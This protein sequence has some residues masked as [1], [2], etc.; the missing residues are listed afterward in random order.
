MKLKLALLCSLVCVNAH[1]Y[2]ISFGTGE[3]ED[4]NI[5]RALAVNDAL[6]QY[7]SKEFD[8]KKQQICSERNADGLDCSFKKQIDIES[9]GTLKRVL[10]EKKKQRKDSCVVEVKIEIEKARPFFASVKAKPEYVAGRKFDFEVFTQE[11]LYVYIF[12]IHNGKDIDMLYPLEDN[13][14]NI[15]DGRME[16]PDTISFQ[17][18]LPS[19]S[20][21]SKET[22]MVVFTKHK[23]TF[24]RP[25]TKQEIYNMISSVPVYSRR[26]MYHNFIIKRR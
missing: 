4:C 12:N 23:L 16:F 14:F 19:G 21:H 13:K 3:D 22:L 9:A 17:A 1:A 11:P 15:V 8:V 18:T 25:S 26:I 20:E 6:E 10:S 7:A 24:K 2:D 5:A